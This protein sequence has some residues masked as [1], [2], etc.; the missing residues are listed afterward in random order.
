MNSGFSGTRGDKSPI[1]ISITSIKV[2][3]YVPIERSL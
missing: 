2:F 3:P 1:I